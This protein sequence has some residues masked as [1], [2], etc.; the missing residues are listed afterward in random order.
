[1]ARKLRIHYPGA[2]YHVMVRGNNKQD[3]FFHDKDRFVFY[4]LMQD[5]PEKFKVKIYAF[6]M[7]KNHV[8]LAIEVSDIPLHKAMHNLNVKYVKYINKEYGKIGHLFQG[9]YKALMVYE[10]E[11]L[12]ALIRYI[13]LNPLRAYLVN[14]IDHYYWSS[15]N[16][17]LK[18]C[19]MPWVYREGGLSLFNN[20]SINEYK[21]FLLSPIN[22]NDVSFFE[23]GWSSTELIGPERLVKNLLFSPINSRVSLKNIEDYYY[24]IYNVDSNVSN[25]LFLDKEVRVAIMIMAD[26]YKILTKTIL[27]DIYKVNR[28]SAFRK[29]VN[30]TESRIKQDRY[31]IENGI[32]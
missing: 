23:N 9:R 28:T 2:Q 7:M 24:R 17:Y 32:I 25:N 8:H 27:A 10:N 20:S 3:I 1:M 6:C 16:Y 13:H 31:N 18:K 5:L 22:K 14:N 19:D 4:K 30:F 12:K 26:A 15:H 29:R 11:Y 21:N